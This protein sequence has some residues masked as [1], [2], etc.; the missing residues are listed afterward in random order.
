MELITGSTSLVMSSDSD[1]PE[2]VHKCR[3]PDEGGE[4]VAG[5]VRVKYRGLEVEVVIRGR[6]GLQYF[7]HT[8][9]EKWTFVDFLFCCVCARVCVHVCEGKYFGNFY[10]CRKIF[11]C[12]LLFKV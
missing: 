1:W 7:Y 9:T 12:K 4:G 3:V 2:A 5:V 11:L 6:E 10:T 8:S